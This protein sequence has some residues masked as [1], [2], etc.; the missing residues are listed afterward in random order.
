[1]PH[2]R[3]IKS[4]LRNYLNKQDF[5]NNTLPNSIQQLPLEQWISPL[6]ACLPEQEP[7]TSRA[8]KM[9][10]YAVAKIYQNKETTEQARVIIRRL[11]WQMNEESGN[12]G[13][14]LPM[15]FAY[16]LIEDENLAKEYHKILISYIRD[17]DG[18]SNFCDFAPLRIHCFNAVEILLDTYPQY[19][20]LATEALIQGMNDCDPICAKKAKELVIKYSLV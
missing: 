2:F 11:I 8:A 14:G 6:F 17:R 18:D 12:I 15:A 4:E 10:G 5:S 9:L 13:W 19:L 7:L 1:M 20:N 3:K 16:C